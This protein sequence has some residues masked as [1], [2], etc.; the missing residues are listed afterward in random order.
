MWIL[1]I[2]FKIIFIKIVF[3]IIKTGLFLFIYYK[4]K[5]LKF[6]KMVINI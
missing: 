5:L 2:T 1:Y 6:Y 3:N 4:K